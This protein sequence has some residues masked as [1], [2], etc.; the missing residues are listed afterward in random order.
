MDSAKIELEAVREVFAQDKFWSELER[1][2]ASALA[3][4]DKADVGRAKRTVDAMLRNIPQQGLF[5]EQ[6]RIL[7]TVRASLPR[8]L[9]EPVFDQAECT[10][11]IPV[12]DVKAADVKVDFRK[13]AV[14][15]R[16][17]GQTLVDGRLF[18][19]VDVDGCMWSLDTTPDGEKVLVL[20]LDKA[21]PSLE[22]KALLADGRIPASDVKPI[23]D[24]ED[25]VSKSG[26]LEG[27]GLEQLRQ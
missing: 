12:D 17:G 21:Q 26:V 4:I 20:N 8:T 13:D 22:W 14:S 5:S 7:E 24:L 2:A 25:F 15:V 10:V 16:V 9:T 27:T 18:D 1:L 23:S 19:T 3:A 11:T 6:R